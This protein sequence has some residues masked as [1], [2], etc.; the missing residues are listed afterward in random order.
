MK[1]VEN[2]KYNTVPMKY[3]YL[4]HYTTWNN[5]V[6]I[7]QVRIH[8]ECYAM[9]AVT[10]QTQYPWLADTHISSLSTNNSE[11]NRENKW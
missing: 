11:S 4:P 5:I 3:A 7:G 1:C 10:T 2:K 9:S 6:E 8:I